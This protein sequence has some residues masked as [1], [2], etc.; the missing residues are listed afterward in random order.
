ML[1]DSPTESL[2]LTQENQNWIHLR[3]SNNFKFNSNKLSHST[4]VNGSRFRPI[5]FLSR[6]KIPQSSVK[7]IISRSN[8][9][10][11]VLIELFRCEVSSSGVN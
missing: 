8:L 9:A 10:V 5:S 3:E 6:Q 11:E 7:A 4:K 1:V 2:F